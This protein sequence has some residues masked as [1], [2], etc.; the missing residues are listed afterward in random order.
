M[1]PRFAQLG[2]TLGS[3]PSQSRARSENIFRRSLSRL[4]FREPGWRRNLIPSA[5]GCACGGEWHDDKVAVATGVIAD[6]V[7]EPGPIFPETREGRWILKAARLEVT[8]QYR[9]VTD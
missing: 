9:I 6:R 4:W 7:Q 8:P 3:C 5:G 2:S 1:H